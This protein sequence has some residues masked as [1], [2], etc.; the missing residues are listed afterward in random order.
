MKI[1]KLRIYQVGDIHF[2]FAWI[3]K[4]GISSAFKDH[5]FEAEFGYKFCP[6]GF[7]RRFNPSRLYMDI[8]IPLR[9][10]EDG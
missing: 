8:P 1:D 6:M 3:T 10:N 9:R 7:D 2:E 5:V 4:R